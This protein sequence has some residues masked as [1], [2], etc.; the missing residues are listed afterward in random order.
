MIRKATERDLDAVAKGYEELFDYE[1][2][3]GT[4]TNWVRGV[5]PT[6]E[7]ARKAMENGTFYV[8]EEDGLICAHMNLNDDQPPHYAEISWKTPAER[9]EVRVIH[10]LCVPPSQKGRGQATKM[11]HFAIDE[12]KKQG[13]K[14]LRIDTEIGN[15]PAQALYAKLGFETVGKK[16]V[17]HE[18]VLERELVFLEYRI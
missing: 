15:L 5:Y 3:N 2:Q 17:L 11:V 14:A 9:H 13:C 6:R 1:D 16:K 4:S 12:A 18:G 8:S 7:T 10:T